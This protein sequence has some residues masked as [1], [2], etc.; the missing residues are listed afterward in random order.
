MFQLSLVCFNSPIYLLELVSRPLPKALP[1]KGKQSSRR[2]KIKYAVLTDT[3]IK[4]E[5]AVI[6]PSRKAKK[7][8]FGEE[9][10]NLRKPKKRSQR[11]IR[12]RMKLTTKRTPTQRMIVFACVAWS[13][14]P[15][16]N[17]KKNGFSVSNARDG[18]MKL[19]LEESSN[20]FAIIAC[21][22]RFWT[23]LDLLPT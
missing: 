2:K 14:S 6:E 15:A 5:I 11:K 20:I 21:Q 23:E 12:K 4:D 16:A 7:R 1:R 8:I 18:H 3:P 13:P 22:T 17:Q 10:K 9:R 19:A